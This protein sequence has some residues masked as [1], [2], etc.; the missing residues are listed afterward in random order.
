MDNP[1]EAGG[2]PMQMR[3]EDVFDVD[4]VFPD[5]RR[6]V[7]LKLDADTGVMAGGEVYVM[8]TCRLFGGAVYDRNCSGCGG[9]EGAR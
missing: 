1:G 4:A 8:G 7:W 2:G 5:R 6:C 9:Y 3:M